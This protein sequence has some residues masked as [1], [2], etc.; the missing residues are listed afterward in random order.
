MTAL[1]Y[2]YSNNQQQQNILNRIHISAT[3]TLWQDQLQ[4]DVFISEAACRNLG[5]YNE[6]RCLPDRCLP[7]AQSIREKH[8]RFLEIPM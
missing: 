5:T 8:P 3:N 7:S 6:E 2:F 1:L 4:E